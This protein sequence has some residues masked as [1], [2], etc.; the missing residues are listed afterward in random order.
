M[1]I[2]TDG[3]RHCDGTTLGNSAQGGTVAADITFRVEQSRN[4]PGFTCGTNGV[5][6]L[7]LENKDANYVPLVDD[8]IKGLLTWAG[9]GDTFNFNL[10]SHGLNANA[11]YSMIYYADGF[12]GN[13]PGYFFGAATTDGIGNFFMSGNPDIH[14]NL[15]TAPDTN[16]PTG[17]KIWLIPSSAYNPGTHSVTTWPFTTDWLFEANLIKYTDPN[18]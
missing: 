14:M 3:T 17:A 11:S 2:D 16:F 12:P 7:I 9:D 5:H 4:N 1:T 6:T 18:L 8:S 15:P 13:H 10:V